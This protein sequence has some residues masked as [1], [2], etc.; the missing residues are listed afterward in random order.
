M[1]IADYVLNM[2]YPDVGGVAGLAL[3]KGPATTGGTT[4]ADADMFL[5]QLVT[6]GSAPNFAFNYGFG[7]TN[8]SYMELGTSGTDNTALKKQGS[9]YETKTFNVA[10]DKYHW[11]TN[12]R[13]I[14]FSTDESDLWGF[15]NTVARFSSAE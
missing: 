15:R 8:L 7:N 3:G 10:A 5:T 14:R 6:G 11:E 9:G 4:P 2:P 1:E 12:L 13:G